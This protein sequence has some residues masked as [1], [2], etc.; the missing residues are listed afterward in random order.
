MEC[1]KNIDNADRHE[2]EK[3]GL[4]YER[5]KNRLHRDWQTERIRE[6]PRKN[7]AA[8]SAVA[9]SIKNFNFQVP[10]VVDANNVI[11]AGHAR[12]KAAR[13]LGLD[14]VPCIV[15]D[16]LTPEQIK[17]FRLADNKVGELA[18]WDFAK[19]EEELSGI[20]EQFDMSTFGFEMPDFE[21]GEES[22]QGDLTEK[23]KKTIVCP[24]CGEIIEI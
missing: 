16:D 11:V 7:E 19:L 5:E 4:I 20:S 24:N 1:R 8:V 9:E 13:L 3:E 18:G 15:A 12:L 23:E 17:A 21:E 22:E 10:I 14:K 6:N 2:K